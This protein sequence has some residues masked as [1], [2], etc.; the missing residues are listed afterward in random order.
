MTASLN[1]GLIAP[2]LAH[3]GPVQLKS[4]ADEFL[5]GG[6][7]EKRITSI[8]TALRAPG[9]RTWR[10]DIGKWIT[11][12]VP[13]ETL[14]LEKY[15]KWRPL[16]ED[17]FQF[18]F[19]HLSNRRLATKILEQIELAPETPP[20][21][22][23][24]TLISKMPG[25]QKLGQVLARNRRLSPAL[26][27]ALSELENSMS[28]VTPDEIRAIVTEQLGMRLERYAVELDAAIFK[29]GSASAILR[30]TWIGPGGDRERGVFKVLKPYVPACFSEDM[31][32]LQQLGQF[33][34]SKDRGYQFEVS[35]VK[36][37]LVEVRLLLEHELDFEREQKTL[38]EAE[39]IYRSS[40]SIRV[41]SLIGPLCT[42]Q[43]TA[44]SEESS[45]KVTDAF[46]RSPVRRARIPDQLI[47]AL[48]AVP[49]FCREDVAVFH[50]DPHA[51]NL[52]YD[53]T[54][55]ELIVMDWALAERLTLESRRQ[56]VLL[57]VMMIL[58]NSAGVRKAIRALG[59]NSPGRRRDRERLIDFHVD[60]F[61]SHLADRPSPG[62]LDAMRLLD[63]IALAGVHFP[64]SLFFFRKSVFTLDGVLQDVAGTD[65]RIDYVI[66]REFLTRWLGSFGMFHAPLQIK[67]FAAVEWQ[68]M[69]FPL[70]S[71]GL[72]LPA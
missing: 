8:E 45:V 4:L 34:A 16:V 5:H 27:V 38:L 18:L 54:N 66:V 61:F 29:E 69:L 15:G 51:G 71:W 52:M 70:R 72:A 40:F 12:I 6:S 14:V 19:S 53:E 44:M 26:R 25:L 36:D 35:D 33:L 23:L 62:T 48:I 56:L 58:R 28:D 7:A 42:A 17:S 1:N 46:A 37:M 30:F 57:V 31:T 43:V 60:R 3:I 68:A 24:L 20:E 50:A 32:L 65:I 11:S 39:H 41:P 13:V 59:R 9:G 47:E 67:D 2:L 63:E 22:R 21:M 64:T 10:A 55:R 49:L